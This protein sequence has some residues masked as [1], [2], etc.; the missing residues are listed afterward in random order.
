MSTDLT[1]I[2]EDAV[3]DARPAEDP[4]PTETQTETPVEASQEPQDATSSESES[5]VQSPAAKLAQAEQDA[6]KD[7]FAQEHGLAAPRPGDRENRIPYSRVKSIAD[8]AVKKA[9]E[10]FQTELKTAK[11]QLTQYEAKVTDYEQ[12]LTAVAQ[13][14]QVMQSDP[15][16]FLNILNQ[17]PAYREI[18]AS[19]Q[20]QAAQTA[21]SGNPSDQMPEP[22]TQ[23]ADGTQSYS[24]EG[25][26]KLL[27]WQAKQVETRVTGQVESRYRPVEQR[28]K[29]M[30]LERQA[31]EH[32]NQLIPVIEGQIKEARTWVQFNE[33]EAEITRLLQQNPTMS[34]EAAYQRVVFPKLVADRDKIR[35]EVTAELRRAPVATSVQTTAS[36]AP[37]PGTGPKSVEDIIRASLEG[38]PGRDQNPNL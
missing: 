3:D 5:T 6:K 11:D 14:E 8:N 17:I 25:L 27:D 37:A 32:L 36:R 2:I 16:R 4:T 35:S 19:L 31:Q 12:R 30:E 26:K 29:E 34:L 15:T 9:V 28:Y 22:D 1:Q 21:N 13:F 20:S 33:N 23:N 38:L 10:P 7:Q 18:F 24:M